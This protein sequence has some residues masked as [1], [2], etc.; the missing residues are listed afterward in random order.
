MLNEYS[1]DV[2]EPCLVVRG[3]EFYSPLKYAINCYDSQSANSTKILRTFIERSKILNSASGCEAVLAALDKE[4]K[5]SVPGKAEDSRREIFA[6]IAARKAGLAVIDEAKDAEVSNLPSLSVNLVD[7]VM[8]NIYLS[9]SRAAAASADQRILYSIGKD[10]DLLSQD[11][12]FEQF[13]VQRKYG[14]L[15]GAA[16]ADTGLGRILVQYDLPEKNLI[17]TNEAVENNAENLKL[18]LKVLNNSLSTEFEGDENQVAFGRHRTGV[19]V[20]KMLHHLRESKFVLDRKQHAELM[21]N[22]AKHS[23][24]DVLLELTRLGGNSESDI[25]NI[26]KLYNESARQKMMQHPGIMAKLS[27]N[28]IEYLAEYSVASEAMKQVLGILNEKGDVTPEKIQKIKANIQGIQNAQLK[29]DLLNA[30]TKIDQTILNAALFKKC[31]SNFIRFLLAQGADCNLAVINSVNISRGNIS[32]GEMNYEMTPLIAASKGDVESFKILCDEGADIGR[33]VK[34]QN[35]EITVLNMI[36]TNS[37][38]EFIEYL[39]TRPEVDFNKP[40]KKSSDGGEVTPLEFC[41]LNY[42]KNN[43]P[44]KDKILYHLIARVDNLDVL[45]KAEKSFNDELKKPHEKSPTQQ[46]VK[47]AF[48]AKHKEFEREQA[49]ADKADL[50]KLMDDFAS[51]SEPQ[52]KMHKKP[53][54]KPEAAKAKAEAAAAK[55]KAEEEEKLRKLAEEKQRIADQQAKAKAAQESKAKAEDEARAKAI[56]KELRKIENEK[57]RKIAEEARLAALEQSRL[58]QEAAEKKLAQEREFNKGLETETDKL[59]TPVLEIALQEVQNETDDKIKFETQERELRIQQQFQQ[60]QQQRAILEEKAAAARA[61][62][63]EA[64]KAADFVAFQKVQ[65]SF[66]ERGMPAPEAP[67]PSLRLPVYTGQVVNQQQSDQSRS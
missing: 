47:D 10:L 23:D 41:I 22:A 45:K 31:D 2:D 44:N 25:F 61:A 13:L 3:G 20:R 53:A 57:A 55:A 67:N 46:L 18:L 62:K 4:L 24:P 8:A 58:S 50:A 15:M 63:I 56:A 12:P 5:I 7:R 40:M 35:E 65:K 11:N 6:A 54:K 64:E 32:G 33:Y 52:K 37:R 49:A 39:L 51:E 21:V 66:I 48:K 16:L 1:L 59:I 14:I 9:Q 38:D 34:I 60:L 17:F 28:Q 26:L 19:V 43:S 29:K 42:L 36:F 30:F 27:P